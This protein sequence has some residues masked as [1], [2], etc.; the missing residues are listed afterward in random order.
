ME[1]GGVSQGFDIVLRG[2]GGS[3]LGGGGGGYVVMSLVSRVSAC[4]IAWDD[5]S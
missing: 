1:S 3:G 4:V 5:V 2:A